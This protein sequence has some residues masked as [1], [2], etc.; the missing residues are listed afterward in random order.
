LT[1]HSLDCVLPGGYDCV[2]TANTGT[3]VTASALCC[4]IS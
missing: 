1:M 3:S 2:I 4:Q